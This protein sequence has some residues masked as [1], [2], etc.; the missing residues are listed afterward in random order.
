MTKYRLRERAHE[1]LLEDLLAARGVMPGVEAAR[2]LEPS[3]ASLLA[4]EYQLGLNVLDDETLATWLAV[5][6][7]HPR[8]HAA[9]LLEAVN[10]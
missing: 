7:E 6:T 4:P 3:Y 9:Q 5:Y 2:F 10:A 1:S 8:A